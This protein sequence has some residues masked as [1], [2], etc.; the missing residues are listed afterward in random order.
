MRE[1]AGRHYLGGTKSGESN[2]IS[3]SFVNSIHRV[4]IG[5]IEIDRLGS[6]LP[7]PLSLPKPF[8]EKITPLQRRMQARPG[9]LADR[10]NQPLVGCIR[11][12]LSLRVSRF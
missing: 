11:S 7:G 1:H 3:F 5:L 4:L 6:P 8:A 9:A 10:L 12:P 2:P